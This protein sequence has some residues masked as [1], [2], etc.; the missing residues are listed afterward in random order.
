MRASMVEDF[1]D[2]RR[3]I[4]RASTVEWVVDSLRT[5]ITEGYFDPGT[6]LSEE[7][8]GEALEVSRNTLREAFRLLTHE[9][10]LEHRRNRGVFVRSLTPADIAELYRVRV[11]LENAALGSL[12]EEFDLSELRAALAEAEAAAQR[13]D[14]QA[15]GTAN[16][17]FH[18]GIVALAGSH[19]L[20]DYLRGLFA[21][22]R[23]A[24]LVLDDPQGLHE[25][26]IRR[27]ATLL[28]LL[29]DG[30]IA[31]AQRELA[32]YLEEARTR[33]TTPRQDRAD[34]D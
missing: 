6:R 12:G 5:R 7:A 18:Q 29:E 21:E 31:G 34:R 16:I 3:Q 27:N 1:A 4:S 22:L 15:V 14:W 17:H 28:S 26:Y 2:D 24:F 23:L 25:P 32:D 11:L 10:L 19:R 13:A 8:L 20:T 9:R 30:D 33:L